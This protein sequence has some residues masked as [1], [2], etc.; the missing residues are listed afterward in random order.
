[1]RPDIPPKPIQANLHTRR[2]RPG[3]LK[4]PRRNSQRRVR[5]HDLHTGDPLCRLTALARRDVA[6]F[7]ARGVYVCNDGAGLVGEGLGRAQVRREG[8]V[9]LEDV[10]FVG[11][12][13]CG[14]GGVGPGTRGGGC[15][16]RG[17]REGAEGDAE[18][19]I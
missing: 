15:V 6:L 13:G 12:A 5:R 4:H 14:G 10:E 2:P 17:E 8:A 7:R 19:E 11:A 9:A 16:G 3:R 1:M 18:V